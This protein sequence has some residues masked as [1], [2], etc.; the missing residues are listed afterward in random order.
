MVYIVKII[1]AAILLGLGSK[2]SV[3]E[4]HCPHRNFLNRH[5][6]RWCFTSNQ[7]E[8]FTDKARMRF[9]NG[10]MIPHDEHP[11]FFDKNSVL[12]RRRGADADPQFHIVWINQAHKQYLLE[13]KGCEITVPHPMWYVQKIWGDDD[14]Y[15]GLRATFA[16]HR[17]MIAHSPENG[18]M[19]YSSCGAENT[20]FAFDDDQSQLFSRSSNISDADLGP[21]SQVA[22]DKAGRIVAETL[23]ISSPMSQSAPDLAASYADKTSKTSRDSPKS[24]RA[25]GDVVGSENNKN[26][27]QGHLVP[28]NF[29]PSR[30]SRESPMSLNAPDQAASIADETSKPP[31][32][33]PMSPRAPGDVVDSDASSSK[34]HPGDEL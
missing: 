1:A 31:R 27:S 10:S 16:G 25:P 34:K 17:C 13:G 6:E 21:M 4:D 3:A 30:T 7:A 29:E 19:I 9:A 32:D 15:M 23:G 18:H 24:P 28:K 20:G 26:S 33:N 11:N 5:Y 8:Q 14:Q 12:T 22:P 2:F